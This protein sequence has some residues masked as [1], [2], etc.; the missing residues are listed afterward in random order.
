MGLYKFKAK[1]GD[2]SV[3]TDV[4]EADNKKAVI[5]HLQE[6]GLFPV[7]ITEEHDRISSRKYLKAKINRSDLVIFHRQLADGL[8]GGLSLVKALELSYKQTESHQLKKVIGEIGEQLQK[9]QSLSLALEKY[10]DIFDSMHIGLIKAG[11]TGGM[12][13][14]SLERIANYQEKDQVLISR[15]KTA[16]AYP[17][18]MLFIGVGTVL[19]LLVLV[20]PKFSLLFQDVE[21]FLPLPTRILIGLSNF[22]I[23]WWFIYVPGLILLTVWFQ[24]YIKTP[25]GNLWF[26]KLKLN[27]FII[28][29]VIRYEMVVRFTRTLGVLLTNGIPMISALEI[30]KKAVGNTLVSLEIERLYTEIKSGKGLVEPLSRSLV[31]PPVVSDLIAAGQEVGSLE[32]SLQRVADTYEMKV[33]NML[34]TMTGLLEPAVIVLM[35]LVVGFIVLAMLLPIFEISGT[36]K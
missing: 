18:A 19:F 27:T 11:E 5:K 22:F 12:L 32:L 13:D 34:K 24:R 26:D 14:A 28:G 29:K 4:L 7:S 30:A 35:G 1:A 20:I 17:L 15:V 25:Q 23:H 6:K 2:G 9:G 21:G 8:K 36:I 31:F 33:E 16:M 3:I 10:P